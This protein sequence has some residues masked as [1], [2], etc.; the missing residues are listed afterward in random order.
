MAW[1]GEVKAE[2]GDD[3]GMKVEVFVYYEMVVSE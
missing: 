3:L 1:M 2:A